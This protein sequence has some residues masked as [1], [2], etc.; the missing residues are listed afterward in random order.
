VISE[1]YE[2]VFSL[3]PFHGI[4]ERFAEQRSYYPEA[5]CQPGFRLVTAR[6]EGAYVGFGYGFPLPK[7][8]RWWISLADPPD[9]EFAR[10]TGTRTFYFVDFGVLPAQRSA[11]V[12][13]RIHDRLLAG[14]GTDRATLA[15]EPVAEA[16][17]ALYR[18]WGWRK[19]SQ[20]HL[21]PPMPAPTLDV[22]VLE[23]MP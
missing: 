18:R 10:E 4:A 16:T 23:T 1:L 21:S 9:A 8:S 22:F 12:G 6:T 17:Q 7:T 20:R 13:R 19:V 3:P 5:T 15:V 14:S 11:G 2:K